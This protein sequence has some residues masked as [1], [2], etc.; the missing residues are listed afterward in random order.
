M[1]APGLNF[2][3]V[4]YPGVACSCAPPDPNGEVGATQ[5]VQ[6]VNQALEVFNKAIGAPVLGPVDIATLWSGFGGVCQLNGDGDPIVLYDQLADRWLISQ[7]AGASVPTDEC[8]AVSQA[9]DATGAYYR[10]DFH[11]GSNFYDYPHLG[12]WPDG[13]YMSDNVFDPTGNSYLGPQPF[14]FDRQAMLAGAPATVITSTSPTIFN[15]SN[16]AI[17]P[18]DLDG[19]IQPP[20]GAPSSPRAE[21]GSS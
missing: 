12:V 3:G 9:G 20:A 1:P 11:L 15:P 8:I 14:A 19:S 2:D 5:Y 7:F 16:D 6:M 17:M 10:Y 4:G 13:Y 21:S 18:A